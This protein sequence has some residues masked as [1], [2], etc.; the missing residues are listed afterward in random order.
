MNVID[1]SCWIEYLKGS[2]LGVLVAALSMAAANV[3]REHRLSMADSI[4][5]ATAMRNAAT[6]FTSDK[7]FQGIE[8]VRY[9]P[10][11]AL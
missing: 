1:S 8:G 9:L 11:P 3:S 2:E 6:L 4:I 7:H 10:K 5:Y